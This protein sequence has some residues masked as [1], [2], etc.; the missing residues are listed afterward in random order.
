MNKK[1]KRFPKSLS[2]ILSRL[3]LYEDMFALSRDLE[4]E[5]AGITDKH[6]PVP[7]VLWALWHTLLSALYYFRLTAQWRSIMLKN[8]V[9]VAIRNLRRHKFFSLI[10]ISGL[11]VGMTACLLMLMF[12]VSEVS[13]DNFHTHLDRIFRITAEW[14]EA[15]NTRRFA[16]SV[17]GAVPALQTEVPGVDAAA[18]LR[19]VPAAVITDDQGRAFR[20]EN[21]Y[22]ADPGILE[23]FSWDL[24][25]G[26]K[27]TALAEPFT[28]VLSRKIAAKY[29]GTEEAVG[30]TLLLKE[31]SYRITGIL[32]DLPPNTHLN[33]EILAS[34]ATAIALGD[35]PEKPWE[36][37]GDDYGYIL[38]NERASAEDIQ[39]R[40][41]GLLETNADP[42]FSRKMSLSLQP[43]AEI[44]W[45]NLS[46]GDVGPK[47]SRL[48]VYLFLS[49]SILVLVIACINFMNLSS[50]RFMDRMKEVGVR[51]VVGADRKQLVH[52]FLVESTMISLIAAL[53]GMYL[54]S[55]L[56]RS[57][58]SLLDLEVVF[59]STHF[60]Y[61]YGIVFLLVI[62]VGILAGAYPALF[63]SGFRP[64]D[65]LKRGG[66]GTRRR[67]SFR[68][69]LVVAQF[70]ISIL[71]ILG[72]VTIRQQI[73]FM[74]NSDLGFEKDGVVLIQLGYGDPEAQQKYPVIRDR[75]LGS[76]NVIQVSGAY[77]VPGVN[78]QFRMSVRRPDAASE[79][80]YSVQ[81]LPGD[82]G[83]AG[84]MGL[85]LVQGRD[86]SSEFARDNRESIVLNETAVKVLGLEH[87]IG[88]KLI[89]SGGE[90]K[91]VIGVVKDFH[92]KSL[93]EEIGPM[94]IDINPRMFGTMAVKI[95]PDNPEET[96][97]F[98]ES[99]W[100]E[101]LPFAD[102]NYRYL[103]DAYFAFYRTEERA[104]ILITIFTGL[105]LAV[106]CLGLF[107]LASFVT[108]KRVKEIGI[109]K[110][111][112]AST[113]R[114]VLMLTRQFALWV[115]LANVFAWPV[116]YWLLRRWLENFA[117][118]IEL[119][120][121]LFIL[122]GAAVLA[123]ALATLSFQSIKAALSDPVDSLRCE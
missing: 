13:Y 11:A 21:V 75:I 45:D 15:G 105:A 57:V 104:G 48:Y 76:P 74:K 113:A 12:V 111:L 67:S 80:S 102:F 108:S 35:Y 32:E 81:V 25:R 119:G 29:F 37:W 122:S 103:E 109:R 4:A 86:F 52:Q 73:D 8:Y 16:A 112:G 94:M 14:G 47:G 66:A 1:P 83:Y 71:L 116:A 34:Y 44:H 90:E 18:R 23:I 85:D 41:N 17:P 33:G 115:L 99:A 61:L 20:E 120:P 96:L 78:S 31:N 89:L 62:S 46:R 19:N 69:V 63:L 40:L 55:H 59:G 10:N 56:S 84:T 97:K 106:S 88:E 3:R 54:F 72:T 7:A 51:K 28:V 5:Y 98:M 36:V 43:L 92:I 70:G 24:I 50:S 42:W 68:Q 65:I 107:G 93:R 123:I 9:M 91:A 117:Y 79:D 30:K 95:R 6:G 27:R 39:H 49:A 2:K 77:T 110:V 87:P 38:L 64:V 101:V 100:K 118:R 58:Y 121:L 22:Y 60:L 114:I 82:Y 53:L 26:D